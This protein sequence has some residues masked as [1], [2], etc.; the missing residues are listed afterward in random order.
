MSGMVAARRCTSTWRDRH[1]R[2][3]VEAS[4]GLPC[5]P[6]PPGYTTLPYCTTWVHHPAVSAVLHWYT[7]PGVPWA[8]S[9]LPWLTPG[10]PAPAPVQARPAPWPSDRA[11]PPCRHLPRRPPGYPALLYPARVYPVLVCTLLLVYPGLPCPSVTP[12][13]GRPG[14]PAQRGGSQTQE[15]GRVTRPLDTASGYLACQPNPGPGSPESR[16]SG[17]SAQNGTFCTFSTRVRKSATCLRHSRKGDSCLQT[18]WI[19]SPG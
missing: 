10:Y 16:K 5:L 9:G 2:L 19:P 18:G 1:V 13:P 14:Y 6:T 12:A 3:Q 8:S 4:S 15:T 7:L 11:L 17:E